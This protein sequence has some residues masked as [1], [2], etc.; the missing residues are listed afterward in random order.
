MAELS[1]K[2]IIAI[3]AVVIIVIAGASVFLLMNKDSGSP[4][5]PVDLSGADLKVLGN[6]D[7]DHDLDNDDIKE[8]EKIIKAEGTVNKYP[9]ADAN[10]DKVIDSKDVDF[11]KAIV[12]YKEGDKQVPVWHVNFKDDGNG[13]MKMVLV[14]TNYP[15]TSTIATG[16]AN[17]LMM[18][19]LMD[20]VDEVKGACYSSSSADKALFDTTFLDKTKC[21]NLGSN[22]GS[23]PFED[24]KIGSSDIIKEKHV[25]GLVTDWNKTYIENEADFEKG[26]VDVV[27]ISAAA[28]TPEE[29]TH[30]ILL[31]GF[32]FQKED[33]AES[34]LEIYGE[35]AELIAKYKS[36]G[37]LKGL[38]SSMADPAKY[39]YVS[40]ADSDYTGVLLE[41][42]LS[43][44]LP[45]YDFKGK[46]SFNTWTDLE[47]YNTAKYHWDYI[48]HIRANINY[49]GNLNTD[50]LKGYTDAFCKYW[51]YTGGEHQYLVS[52]VIPVPLR[53]LYTECIF[54]EDL[55]SSQVDELHQKFV[56]NFY[57]KSDLDISKMTFFVEGTSLYE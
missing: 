34:L 1:N 26:G 33:R 49:S 56:K 41:A 4:S 29:Y 6:A 25:T 38:A 54:N 28:V 11:V 12:E 10:N 27:R 22:T 17:I 32:L 8:I 44:G 47:L 53:V 50:T 23:I 21:E 48:V 24:G 3:V 42:G 36:D 51:E 46:T 30:T 2:A 15:I 39:A 14:E 20:I 5:D 52:G 31:L 19:Q 7:G 35:A 16:S 45:G 18:L 9:L 13:V 37:S 57:I 55:S 40:S 43:F